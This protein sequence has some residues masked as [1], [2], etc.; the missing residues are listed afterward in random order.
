MSALV[1]IDL[2][3]VIETMGPVLES[4]ETVAGAYLFGSALGP[5]RPDSDIDVGLVLFPDRIVSEKAG[6]FLLEDILEALPRIDHHPYDLVILNQVSALFA[7]R[8]ISQGHEIYARDPEVM[9]D[10]MERVSR[11]RGEDYPRYR[12]ALEEIVKG[13]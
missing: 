9:S 11:R 6:E 7:F 10:F 3:Q 8:V 5:C 12:R 4:R 2:A 1:R 13:E